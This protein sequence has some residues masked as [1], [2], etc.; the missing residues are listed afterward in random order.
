MKKRYKFLIVVCLLV[1]SCITIIQWMGSESPYKETAT[2]IPVLGYHH[3]ASD[4]DKRSQWMLDP[5]TSSLSTFEKQMKYLYEHGY[6]TI[7]LDDLYAWYCGEKEFSNKTV[8]LTFDDSYY[9]TVALAKP[10]L[11]TY[12]FQASVFVIGKSIPEVM[13]AYDAPS[14]QHIPKELLKDDETLS[15][16]SHFYHLHRKIDGEYA[17]HTY[18]TQALHD[19][20]QEAGKT[21]STDYMAYPYGKYDEKIFPILAAE[22]VDLAFTYHDYRNVRRND[23]PYCL[24]RYS[25]NAYTPMFLFQWYVNRA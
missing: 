19:D 15:F 9:S 18:D 5:W 3:L 22:Q 2:S 17:I 7:S 10:I 20:I 23:A 6:Q 11:E 16:Y 8:V 24:P 4:E 13:S 1:I 25:I 21:V 14:K 12:G